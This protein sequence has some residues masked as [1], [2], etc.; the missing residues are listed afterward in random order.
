MIITWCFCDCTLPNPSRLVQRYG[1]WHTETNQLSTDDV[2]SDTVRYVVWDKWRQGSYGSDS[3][4]EAQCVREAVTKYLRTRCEIQCTPQTALWN[5][6]HTSDRA[7]K[8]S[9]HLRLRC[10]MQCTPQSAVKCSSHIRM[11]CE[12][13]CTH[14]NVLWNPV[15]TSVCA[16]KCSAHTRPRCEMQ[17]T[18]QTALWNAVHTSD[19]ADSVIIRVV[20]VTSTIVL[21]L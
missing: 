17:C 10:E 18:P 21:L 12:M 13:Q 5:A 1:A 16:V 7:V 11:C 9:A 6:V 8:C 2:S 4:G 19:H 14:Q 3:K 15:H 20:L